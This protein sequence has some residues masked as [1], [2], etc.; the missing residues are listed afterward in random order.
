MSLPDEAILEFD[1]VLTAK[2]SEEIRA[3]LDE[4]KQAKET[5]EV[6]AEDE[7]V[8]GKKTEITEAVDALD[9]NDIKQLK[10]ILGNPQGFV[11]GGI[12]DVFKN[13]GPNAPI[14]LGIVGLVIASPIL[15]KELLK[16]LAVKGGPL[17]RDWRRFIQ[18]EIDVGLSREQQKQKEL[19]FDQ[20]IL[21]QILGFNPNS[22]SFTYNSL[23]NIDSSRI[24]RIG[25]SDRA[26]G[27]LTR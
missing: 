22:E 6:K 23:F 14:I 20:V 27:V 3:A 19:G 25:L 12:T 18:K 17:N 2:A 5:K 11:K 16:A 13:L 8:T 21:T 15:I 10:G 7:G 1:I 24:A 9:D 26:A 4:A